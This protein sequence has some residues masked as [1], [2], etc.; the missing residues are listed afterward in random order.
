V[1]LSF[2]AVGEDREL[3]ILV[4]TSHA[5]K[6]RLADDEPALPVEHQSVGAGPRAE[7][8]DFSVA[9]ATIDVPVA[10]H[11]EPP[12]GMPGTPFPCPGLLQH[13]GLCAWGENRF[14]SG[15]GPAGE[16]QEDE[17]SRDR[18]FHVDR[19]HGQRSRRLFGYHCTVPA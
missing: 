7:D 6:S 2:V 8:R 5:A 17:R 12:F 1:A 4:E 13:P 10:A 16:R 19:S 18:S 9:V 15:P 11:E 14:L 3:P